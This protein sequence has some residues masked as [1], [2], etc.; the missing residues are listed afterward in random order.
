MTIEQVQPEH[1]EWKSHWIQYVSAGGRHLRLADN[2]LKESNAAKAHPTLSRFDI[3]LGPISCRHRA[4]CPTP[5]D[6]H[7]FMV[8]TGENIEDAK[9]VFE[10]INQRLINRFKVWYENRG[11]FH[12]SLRFLKSSF[13]IWPCRNVTR[14]QIR[15]KIFVSK[16]Y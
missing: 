7:F 4:I 16:S 13:I 15:K 8:W 5:A 14:I 1:P 6:I 2:Q 11:W 10:K 3:G 9:K 12:K